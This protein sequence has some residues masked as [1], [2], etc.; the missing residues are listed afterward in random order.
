MPPLLQPCILSLPNKQHT[1][2][3]RKS[4]AKF[5][6]TFELFDVWTSCPSIEHK[7]FNIC[8]VLDIDFFGVLMIVFNFWILRL[9]CVF[10]FFLGHLDFEQALKPPCEMQINSELT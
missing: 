5:K 10:F 9:F 1:Q 4:Q 3:V 7:V 6:L 2:H 8:C